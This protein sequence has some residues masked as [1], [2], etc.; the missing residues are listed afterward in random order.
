MVI[1]LKKRLAAVGTAV[2]FAGGLAACSNGSGRVLPTP[3]PRV[4][5]EK[6]ENS[7]GELQPALK[8]EEVTSATLQP[9]GSYQAVYEAVKKAQG[10]GYDYGDLWLEDGVLWVEEEVSMDTADA[11]FSPEQEVS[12][13]LDGMLGGEELSFSGTNVQV[14][15]IDEGDIIKTDGEFLYIFDENRN[16]ISIVHVAE[17]SMELVSRIS[18]SEEFSGNEVGREMYL[19]GNRL[20][21]IVSGYRMERTEDT[22]IPAREDDE[23]YGSCAVTEI[24]T[25]DISK[26]AAPVLLSSLEQDGSLLSSRCT[27]GKVYVISRYGNASYWYYDDRLLEEEKTEVSEETYARYSPMA[28]GKRIPA[29]CIYLSEEPVTSNFLVVAA[30]SPEAPQG[31]LD[32]MSLLADGEECYVSNSYIYVGNRR[33]QNPEI[34]YDRT[35]LYRF[36]YTDGKITPAGQVTVKGTLDGQ[37]S[38]DEAKGYLRVVTTVTEY[39]YKEKY[40]SSRK[41]SNALYI[42]DGQLALTGSIEQLAPEE[43]IKSAR[44][45]GDIGYFVTFRQTDPLFSVDLSDP[46]NPEVLGT[47]KIPGFS[48]YLHPYGENLLLGIG[49]AADEVTGRTECVKLSMFDVSDPTDVKEVHTMY[50]EEFTS[51]GV[52]G[53][54]KAA[55]VDVKKDSIGL[56]VRGWSDNKEYNVYVVFGYDAENGFYQKLSEGYLLDWSAEITEF[57]YEFLSTDCRGIYIGDVFYIVNPAYEIKAYNMT[58]WTQIGR[59]GL[60][61]ELEERQEML[62]RIE[63]TNPEPVVIELEA[64]PSTGYTWDVATEGDSVA[65]YAIE[66]VLAEETKQLPGAPVTQRYVF[67]IN[68]VG[69]TTL[70]FAY[71]RAWEQKTP[72][73]TIVYEIFVD[74]NLK[75]E[76]TAIREG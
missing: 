4:E 25:Y 11:T 64:N 22:E 65:L 48:A 23:S 69:T 7:G 57:K 43:Q 72:L 41:E 19:V 56:P 76:V 71:A 73:R 14:E 55:L 3:T 42:Y 8:T 61:K 60:V 52:E 49:Y 38:M 5:K 9:A 58:D 28:G 66:T 68:N 27:G 21:L 17:G 51:T 37:F 34:P 32:V 70:T 47:L 54:H 30:M 46:A 53:S 1:Q 16:E 29:D 40:I 20:V 59:L 62:L 2:L 50:L 45:M 33:W 26:K 15:G 6:Q 10:Y 35:E 39:T 44:L 67:N 63:E 31:F 18:A 36:A 75:A 12:V 13:P 74:D 24:L